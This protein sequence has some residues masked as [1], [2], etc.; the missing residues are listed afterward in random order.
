MEKLDLNRGMQLGYYRSLKNSLFAYLLTLASMQTAL[1]GEIR[2]KNA[3]ELS[4]SVTNTFVTPSGNVHCAVISEKQKV[5][6]CEIQ[7]GLHPVPPQPYFGYC[8]FDWGLGFSLS[9][10]GKPKI[11]C[12]S[13]TI[14]DN[15]YV[16]SYGNTWRYLGFKCV[17]KK[18]GLICKNSIGKGFLLNRNKWNIF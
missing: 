4:R 3:G 14:S 11:L 17:S 8:K 7:S 1:A 12:I 16:L 18:T 9:Q 2:S 10:Q 5:L 13:D 15:N 6:R